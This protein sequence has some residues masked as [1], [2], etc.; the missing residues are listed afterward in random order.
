MEDLEAQISQR[1]GGALRESRETA[2][3]RPL[4]LRVETKS[5]HANAHMEGPSPLPT[6]L[7]LR[8]STCRFPWRRP[9]TTPAIRARAVHTADLSRR[10][11]NAISGRSGCSSLLWIAGGSMLGYL[12]VGP[13]TFTISRWRPCS[14]NLT[15]LVAI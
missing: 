4:P 12:L 7:G 3:E 2:G 15:L 11:S 14:T 8:P 9:M 10:S 13:G 6:T 1:G 5:E